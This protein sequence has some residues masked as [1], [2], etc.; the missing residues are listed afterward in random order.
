M[1]LQDYINLA[2]ENWLIHDQQSTLGGWLRSL[3]KQMQSEEHSILSKLDGH[4]AEAYMYE[5]FDEE[6]EECGGL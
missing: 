5:Y 1:T 6:K 3:C 4:V 2:Y